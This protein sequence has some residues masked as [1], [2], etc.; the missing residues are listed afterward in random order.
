MAGA[1]RSLEGLVWT[2]NCRSQNGNGWTEPHC[3]RLSASPLSPPKRSFPPRYPPRPFRCRHDGHLNMRS[4][5]P[6]NGVPPETE[7]AGCRLRASSYSQPACPGS[8]V[9]SHPPHGLTDASAL[10]SRAASVSAL[11]RLRHHLP[12]AESPKA[13]SLTSDA[14]LLQQ[15]REQGWTVWFKSP[16]KGGP[17]PSRRGSKAAR[18]AAAAH[19]TGQPIPRL[20][21]RLL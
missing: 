11:F 8:Q 9:L 13:D 6:S 18:L 16:E 17:Q 7:R 3:P 21:S 14:V 10:T 19:P 2:R 12:G 20:A 1:A 4:V 15:L 5:R